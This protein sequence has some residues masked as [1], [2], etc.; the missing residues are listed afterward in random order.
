[1][2]VLL[3][4]STGFLGRVILDKLYEAGYRITI[5]QRVAN[6]LD[7]PPDTAS[8]TF[9]LVDSATL[10]RLPEDVDVV[11]HAAALVPARFDDLTMADAL[12]QTNGLGTLQLALWAKSSGV[13]RFIYCSSHSIYRRPFLFPISETH[14]VYPCGSAVPYALS[15]L[16]GESFA[17]QLGDDDFTVCSLR[18]SAIY[19]AGMPPSGVLPT[20]IK[21]ARQ[22]AVLSLRAHPKSLFD[23]VHVRDAAQAAVLAVE[24]TLHHQVYN[25]GGEK[26][27][28]LPQ[29]AEKIWSLFAPT[30]S[31]TKIQ[32]GNHPS[33]PIFAVLDIG[34]ARNDLGYCPQYNLENLS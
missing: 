22:N 23:F 17:L 27:I 12:W 8:V 19:G 3:T 28:T 30:E 34:R 9:D 18:F 24:Q 32:Q 21:L 7:L 5:T 14:P 10:A 6:K 4:G 25:V 31:T 15:K 13:K 26:G 2:H 1:M 16:A 11:I 20:F 33:E 29:L